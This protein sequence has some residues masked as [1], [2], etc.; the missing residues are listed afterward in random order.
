MATKRALRAI[1]KATDICAN[2]PQRAAEFLVSKGHASRYDYA[3]QLITELSYRTWRDYDSE[4]SVRFWALRLREAGMIK[5]SSQKI[6][7]QSTDWH[8]LNALK[9][10]LR[11]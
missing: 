2:D 9:K 6:T 4:D 5:S 3:Y 7:T 11:V 10:E 1:L 8:F